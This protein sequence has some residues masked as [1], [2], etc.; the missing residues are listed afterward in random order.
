MP[1]NFLSFGNVDAFG[2]NVDPPL[3]FLEL[4]LLSEE[5]EATDEEFAKFDADNFL[6]F[7][8]I[9]PEMMA[10]PF[11]KQDIV[12]AASRTLWGP[13]AGPRGWPRASSEQAPQPAAAV[14]TAG[15]RMPQTS[16]C[17]SSSWAAAAS[18]SR[19]ACR[20]KPPAAARRPRADPFPMRSSQDSWR[21]IVRVAKWKTIVVE[22]KLGL[23]GGKRVDLR[24]QDLFDSD[25]ILMRG[26]LPEVSRK[27]CCN[28]CEY[29]ITCKDK[30]GDLILVEDV[31]LE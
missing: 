10:L 21:S 19:L 25:Q 4:Y 15:R 6:I 20:V 5:Q 28:G 27:E 13:R 16:A 23:D 12:G 26:K 18:L 30:D 14:L 31:P 9:R 29:S 8:L 11:R 17:G 3:H 2:L 7:E 22:R 24:R 1:F